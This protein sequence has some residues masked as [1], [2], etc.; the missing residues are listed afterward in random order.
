M[1]QIARQFP[2]EPERWYPFGSD[3][4]AF[5]PVLTISEAEYLEDERARARCE[6]PLFTEG[7]E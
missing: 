7:D 3:R 4:P 6:W 2:D 1:S 5:R